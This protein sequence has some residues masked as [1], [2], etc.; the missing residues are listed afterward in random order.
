M[1]PMCFQDVLIKQLKT[2]SE[3]AC[4]L[5]EIMDKLGV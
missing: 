5:D 2:L 4:E 3:A 1:T